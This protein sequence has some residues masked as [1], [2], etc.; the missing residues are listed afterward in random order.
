MNVYG[1]A[2]NVYVLS[3]PWRVG[4][5]SFLKQM[6]LNIDLDLDLSKVNSDITWNRTFT[7]LRTR[8]E[9]YERANEQPTKQPNKFARS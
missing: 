9:R 8:I 6:T 5:G 2:A 1:R 3:S 7:F 4:P